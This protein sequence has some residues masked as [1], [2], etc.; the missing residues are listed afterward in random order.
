MISIERCKELLGEAEM[1]DSEAERFRG[2]LYAMAESIL[3]HYFE[4][5][6]TINTC[7]K[8]SS[9]AEYPLQNKALKDTCLI[10]KNTVAESMQS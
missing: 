7:K 1:P 4:E 9:I 10:A 3:D 8:Q 2:A 6:A 5:F